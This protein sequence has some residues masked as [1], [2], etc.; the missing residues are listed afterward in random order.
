MHLTRH[1]T[2]S[3]LLIGLATAAIAA[4]PGTAHIAANWN[5]D[6]IEF[7]DSNLNVLGGFPSGGNL[8]NG[9]AFDG[10]YL[11]SGHFTTAEVRAFDLNGNFAFNWFGPIGG[12]QGMEYVN[13]TGELAIYNAASDLVEFYNPL[14]GNPIRSVPGLGSTIEGLAWDGAYLWQLDDS[15]IYATDVSNG[16]VLF[17]VPNPAV[18]EAFGGTAIDAPSATELVVG[19]ASGNWWRIDSGTGNILAS[20]NNGVSMYGLSYIPEPASL[21]LLAIGAASLFR[22]R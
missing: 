18:N 15:V 6:N 16:N 1:L 20:G 3:A 13:S 7:L 10:T 19:G 14:N 8:P 2:L 17:T 12:L 4:P 11:Y 5:N 21:V 22:R 9:T